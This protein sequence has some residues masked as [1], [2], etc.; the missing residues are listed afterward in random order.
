VPGELTDQPAAT[1]SQHGIWRNALC[2]EEF[3]WTRVCGIWH[4]DGAATANQ[5]ATHFPPL[6]LLDAAVALQHKGMWV[7]PA[8]CRG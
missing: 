5:S 4:G 1:F 2:V 3:F 8:S 7:A 6:R